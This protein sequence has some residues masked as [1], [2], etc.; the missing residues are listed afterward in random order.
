MA[1]V[2]L[3]FNTSNHGTKTK[4]LAL[5]LFVA[6]FGLLEAG[7]VSHKN[8]ANIMVKNACDIIFGGMAYWL[9]GF[10]F[11][12]GTDNEGSTSFEFTG[13]GDYA[14]NVDSSEERM[15][16]TYTLFV[17]QLSFA[18]TATTI[19]S[20]AIAERTKLTSYM[21]FAFFNILTYCFPAHWIWG[22]GF[23]MKKGVIDIAGSGVVHLKGGISALVGAVMLGPRTGRYARGYHPPPLGNGANVI[24]GTFMLW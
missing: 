23:L 10:A 14:L 12:F 7:V 13:S 9:F 4:P 5:Y 24:V 11:S 15:G 22:G 18:A 17:F 3:V 20:G 1:Y 6:G 21:L 16:A 2:L 19:V 8:E